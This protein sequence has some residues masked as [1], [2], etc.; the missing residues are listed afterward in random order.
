M[1]QRPRLVLR[2]TIGRCMSVPPIPPPL[3]EVGPRPF[4]F[5]PPIVGIEHNEWLY[6]KANW[7][8]VLVLN[9]KSQIE[10]WIPR[11]YIG[12]V[13]R[14]DEPMVIVGLRKELEFKAG[15]VWPYVRRVIEMPR[16]V[17]DV[18]RLP[19]DAPAGPAPVIGIRLENRNELRI[20][21]LIGA[22]LLLGTIGCVLMVSIFRGAFTGRGVR[23]QPVLQ[24]DLGLNATDDYFS[25]VRKYGTPAED[26]WRSG[27]GALQYRVLKYPGRSMSVIL[28]GTERSNVLYIGAM[29]ADWRPID[30]VTMRGGGDTMALLRALPRF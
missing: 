18:P 2:Y 6:R 4:S 7:S 13:S 25:V 24:T 16:A 26:H 19:V 10:T 30:S 8:E 23:Y 1:C 12:E 3:D 15:S 11:H 17:N 29:D 9:T 28:M 14:V 27:N 20:G 5:Y 21:R 22:A